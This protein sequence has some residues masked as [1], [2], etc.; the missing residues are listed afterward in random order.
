MAFINGGIRMSEQEEW[1]HMLRKKSQLV[2][3]F[4]ACAHMGGIPGLANLN[5]RQQ[6]FDTVYQ[7]VPSQDNQARTIPGEHSR[8]DGH[9]LELPKFWDKVKALNQ[10]I[11]VD[12]YLPGCA[13]PP[14][15]I[16][17]AIE[18]I[19]TGALPPKGAVLS[20]NVAC[21]DDCPRKD[22]KPDKSS[23][24]KSSGLPRTLRT[25][26]CASWLGMVS[27][28]PA[29]FGRPGDLNGYLPPPIS[30]YSRVQ[31]DSG[32]CTV[33][34][35]A[36]TVALASARLSPMAINTCDGSKAPDEHADPVPIITP[37]K[38]S[39]SAS[40]S[41]PGKVRL[42]VLGRRWAPRALILSPGMP[43]SRACSN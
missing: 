14:K 38:F 34:R 39:R 31:F 26:S 29:D 1:V 3:A 37:G 33:P 24:P 30:T 4:G 17:G 43:A 27:P 5:H 19:L 18:A 23:S 15:L 2:V 21:C 32:S 42:L 25:R 22:T 20:P 35:L 41:M 28:L 13:P 40:A 7:N 11:D 16:W 12:Y 10:V 9:D 36:L 8:M 6:V